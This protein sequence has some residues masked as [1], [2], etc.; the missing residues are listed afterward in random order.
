MEIFEYRVI[1]ILGF[2][3]DEYER[4]LNM[5]GYHGFELFNVH[6]IPDS[7]FVSGGILLFFKRLIPDYPSSDR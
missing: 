2:D 5:A 4:R 7:F 3:A 1:K 6:V